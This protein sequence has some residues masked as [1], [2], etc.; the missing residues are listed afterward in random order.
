MPGV[1][2]I[3][4]GGLCVRAPKEEQDAAKQEAEDRRATREQEIAERDADGDGSCSG[5]RGL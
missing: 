5:C 1:K 2:I 3:R 4:N